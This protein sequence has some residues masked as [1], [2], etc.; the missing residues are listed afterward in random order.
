MVDLTYELLDVFMV[1]EE[2]KEL[3]DKPRWISESFPVYSLDADLAKSSKRYHALDP[4]MDFDGDMTQLVGQPCMVTI[5]HGE[6][7]KNPERPYENIGNVSVMRAKEVAKAPELVNE[8]TVFVLD[9]PDMEVFKKLPQW[10]QE[11]V[12]GNL[13]Y[14]G[15]PLQA[16][17]EAS[18]EQPGRVA[19]GKPQKARREAPVDQ[20][21]NPEE[22]E[23][24]W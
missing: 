8:P 12:K 10:L 7:R 23:G 18:Q 14:A 3:E 5:V 20:D 1:D 15:S 24:E 19:K 22:G 17:L 21:D 11:K 16:L 13:E 6:N 4:N 9:D 2:G